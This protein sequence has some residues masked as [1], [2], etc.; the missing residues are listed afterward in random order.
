M[1]LVALTHRTSY[2]YDRPVSLGPQLIRL[3]PAPHART[4]ILRY[5][6]GIAPEPHLLNWQQDPHGNFLARVL[7][8]EPVTRFEA[9]VDLIADMASINPFDFLL[10][11]QA[12][13][14]PFAYDPVLDEGLLP[15]RTPLPAGPL[16][17]DLLAT[18]PRAS[19]PTMPMLVALNERLRD[20]VEYVVRL[21]PGVWSAE[22]T[23]RQ[24]RGSCR[25]SAWLLVQLARHLGLAA[26]FVSGYLI[27][28]A[29]DRDAQPAAHDAAADFAALHAWAEIYLPGAGWIGFDVTS[30]LLASEGHIPLAASLQPVSAAAI[31]GTVGRCETQLDFAIEVT[32]LAA[33]PPEAP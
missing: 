29:A 14:W 15:S 19:Q 32:R 28:L 9:N 8:P 27:Q 18:V 20:R 11:A 24:G 2:R 5:A 22:E 1:S 6:L 13:R 12:E 31:S 23:L 26:R 7:F 16:L 17:R 25:D 33:T 3:R 10:E 21:E 4:P 30:G